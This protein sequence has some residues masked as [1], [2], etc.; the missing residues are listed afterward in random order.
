M[1]REPKPRRPFLLTAVALM[2]VLYGAYYYSPLS[3]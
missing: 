3:R 2:C 1:A